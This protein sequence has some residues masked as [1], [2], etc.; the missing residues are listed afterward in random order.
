MAPLSCI[1]LNQKRNRKIK[2]DPASPSADPTQPNAESSASAAE[3]RCESHTGPSKSFKNGTLSKQQA[4]SWTNSAV[5]ALQADASHWT[6]LSD[7]QK[8]ASHVLLGAKTEEEETP[9]CR[10]SENRPTKPP[11]HSRRPNS[12]VVPIKNFT[13]LPPIKSPHLN[14]RFAGQLCVTRG[15]GLD[16]VAN[17]EFSTYSAALTSKYQPGQHNLSLFSPGSVSVPKRL[18][19]PV[20][21]P[22]KYSLGRSLHSTTA[23][24]A[25]GQ[26]Q[27]G[28][29]FS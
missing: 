2:H 11:K 16:A 21:K 6:V 4:G 18:Q 23:A 29:L 9:G 20:P 26:M 19:V 14:P 7:V 15:A 1:L 25:Q 28:Y 5:A 10:V 3:H 24:G 17:I 8:T 22:D 12:T 27:P 13:F